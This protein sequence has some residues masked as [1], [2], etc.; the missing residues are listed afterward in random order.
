MKVSLTIFFFGIVWL[1]TCLPF[2]NTW[3]KKTIWYIPKPLQYSSSLLFNFNLKAFEN[4]AIK[5]I[6]NK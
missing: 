5:A 3:I 6:K 4:V 1:M 2:C